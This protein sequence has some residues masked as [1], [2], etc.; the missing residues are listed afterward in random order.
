M[1]FSTI[2]ER[3]GMSP[4]NQRMQKSCTK[5]NAAAQSILHCVLLI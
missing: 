4:H 2:A 1:S 5:G 3:Q